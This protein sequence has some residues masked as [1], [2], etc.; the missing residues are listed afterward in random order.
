MNKLHGRPAWVG[1]KLKSLRATTNRSHGKLYK[2]V[3]MLTNAHRE[4]ICV[5]YEGEFEPSVKS[6]S[7]HSWE[8]PKHTRNL[9]DWW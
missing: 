4:V 9:P 7:M 5:W 6:T 2:I 1:M 8:V 3:D